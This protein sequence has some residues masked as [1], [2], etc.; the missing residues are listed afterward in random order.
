MIAILDYG[1]GNVGSIL[2]MLKKVSV[3]AGIITTVTEIEEAQSLIIPGVGHIDNAIERLESA[4]LRDALDDAAMRRCIPILGI[5]LG[6]QIMSRSSEEGSR[7]GL[8]WVPARATRFDGDALGLRVPHMGWNVV[9]LRK[10]SSCFD[11]ESFDEHRFYFVHSYAVQCE[12]P[13]DVLTTTT[14]GI[15][16]VS[17][18]QR[19]NLMGVQFHPEKS[20]KFGESFFRR[21]AANCGGHSSA[22]TS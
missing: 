10:Q 6:M 15:E 11:D 16:F 12:D 22:A 7:Q 19:G 4:G 3:D 13:A 9:N 1:M 20:H 2:N 17:A 18:F 8:G 5:C 14:Y 21:Y